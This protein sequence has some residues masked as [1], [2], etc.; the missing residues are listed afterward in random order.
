MI[1]PQVVIGSGFSTRIV[2]ISQEGGASAGSLR[3]IRSTSPT[4]GDA[5]VPSAVSILG[6]LASQHPYRI[7]SGGGRQSRPGNTA[8]VANIELPE[9]QG[10]EIPVQSGKSVPVHP[11]V[12]DSAGEFRDDFELAFESLDPQVAT[13]DELGLIE[14]KEPGFSSLTVSSGQVSQQGRFS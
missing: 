12:I 7:P 6:S 4:Q 5:G 3:F 8:T 1:L 2:F 10:N 14:G 11:Q 13:V 9:L